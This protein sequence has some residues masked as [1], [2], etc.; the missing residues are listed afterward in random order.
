[1]NWAEVMAQFSGR[2]ALVVGDISLD[3]WCHYDPKEGDPSRETGI[4]RTAVLSTDVSPGAGG[5]VANN[6]ASLGAGEVAVLG[7]IGQDGF[8][9]E[10]ERSLGRRGIDYKLLVASPKV[11][12][13]TYTKVINLD[14]GVED[15]PRIDFI[16]T[17]PLPS[18]VEDQLIVNFHSAFANYDVIIVS[19]QAE[20]P[21]GGVITPAFRE[22]IAD[23]A[24]RDPERVVI[25]DSRMRVE[26]FRNVIAKPNVQEA[27]A[28][29]Q[30][31]F[32][33]IDYSLLRRQISPKPLVVT[34]GADGVL[35]IDDEGEHEI[36]AVAVERPV[37]I[38]GAGDAFA[39]GFGLALRSSGDYRTASMFGALA[40]RV[41]IMKEGT[42]TAA[43]DE[44]LANEDFMA[45][46]RG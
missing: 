8:G 2:K 26:L 14:T 30:R 11:Q 16:N 12:T 35:L 37:N 19:D 27:S 42:G 46:S 36:P 6:L 28:A 32:R 20:T 29:C 3:R 34:R 39:A 41:V 18:E 22:V 43:P 38:C 13:F 9:F 40:A 4:P 33:K 45:D 24:E 23:A 44:I 25:V 17:K 21:H 7:A 10:L 1:M 15:R 31:L 5:T